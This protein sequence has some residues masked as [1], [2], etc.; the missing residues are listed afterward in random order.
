MQGSIFTID[1]H[2][3]IIEMQQE[4]YE[5][6]DLFQSLIE[7]YPALLAGEQ[8]S[9]DNPRRW[10][11]VARE[12]GV[13]DQ[14]GGGD[15]WYLDHLFIDQDAIPTLV[16]VK[17]AS[18]TRI[19]REVVAQMLDYAANAAAYW[20]I[21]FLRAQYEEQ[22][23]NNGAHN[24]ADIGVDPDSEDEFWQNV[25]AN[26]R[27][28]RMRLLFVADKIPMSLQSI[29][30]FLNAQMASVEVLGLEIHQFS[31]KK[32][33]KTLVPRIIGRTASA[34]QAKQRDKHKWT[35]TEFLN[36]MLITTGNQACVDFCIKLLRAF[37]GLGLRIW[38]GEGKTHGSFVV[39]HDGQTTHQLLA[40]WPTQKGAVVELYFQHLK[41]PINTQEAKCELKR[42]FEQIKGLHI[43]DEKLSKRPNIQWKILDSDDALTQFIDIIA[44]MRTQITQYEATE[45]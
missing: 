45:A 37:E 1:E 20:S 35:E 33:I 23:M 18:D 34:T 9:P 24:L 26:L 4:R 15:H 41:A 13:P 30:E 19:R 39:I 2:G 31:S 28:G 10:I 44:A 25:S 29:I 6:E 3:T 27:I 42:K 38:W 16:E 14:E 36:D 7:K 11:F 32:G 22:I 8:I 21:D 12:L 43:P 17:R 40:V 5:N